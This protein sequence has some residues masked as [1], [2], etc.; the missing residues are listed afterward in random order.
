MLSTGPSR[1]QPAKTS[2]RKRPIAT[3]C[4]AAGL[5]R[6]H[7]AT[8]RNLLD[9]TD[10]YLLDS[11]WG[12]VTSDVTTAWDR[13][14]K[15]VSQTAGSECRVR[16]GWEQLSQNN[17][18]TACVS[19]SY[20][21]V[22][23]GVSQSTYPIILP[24]PCSFCT[25]RSIKITIKDL[26][27]RSKKMQQYAGIY[28]PQI[29][30]TCFGCPSHPSSGVHKTNCSLWYGSYHVTVQR[31]SSN[32]ARLEE[33]RCTVTWYDL[34]QRLQLQFYVL[35]MMGAMDTRNM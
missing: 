33:G 21:S 15:L 31:P 24:L 23:T 29:Y 5:A 25:T 10:G 32:A 12:W 13:G 26:L 20:G 11:L 4:S 18:W 27:I 6:Q 35:L 30:S 22:Q 9:A 17:F 16:S 2:C 3:G 19:P 1:C 28:L 14:G 34:Y 8:R 7:C